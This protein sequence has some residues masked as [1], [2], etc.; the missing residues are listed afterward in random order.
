M[1]P[2]SPKLIIFLASSLIAANPLHA[3]STLSL[4][5]FAT[6][7]EGW[8]IGASGNLMIKLK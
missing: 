3:I 1:R 7:S 5:A 6:T 8:Q 2:G 4:D